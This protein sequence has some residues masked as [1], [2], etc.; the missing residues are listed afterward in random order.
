MFRRTFSFFLYRLCSRPKKQ[1]ELPNRVI[2]LG[3]CEVRVL[4]LHT[5]FWNMSS[6]A[7]EGLLSILTVLTMRANNVLSTQNNNDALLSVGPL[8][9]TADISR[10]SLS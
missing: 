9:L 6:D 10:Y 8:F 7:I 2:V 5:I 1:N 4:F 3:D